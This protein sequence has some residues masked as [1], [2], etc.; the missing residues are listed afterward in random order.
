[1]AKFTFLEKRTATATKMSL[2]LGI[3]SLA[4]LL[5]LLLLSALGVG[6]GHNVLGAIGLAAM[7]FAWYAFFLG[8][9]VLARRDSR[10]RAAA[11]A[12]VVS[13]VASIAW[14]SLFL[15]GVS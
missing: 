9:R 10:I 2:I 5:V 4:V 11:V 14:I 7:L 3:A 8:L 1:M 6:E 15:L 12:T 13:G